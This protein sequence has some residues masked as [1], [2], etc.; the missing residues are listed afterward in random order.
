MV[1]NKKIMSLLH[2]PYYGAR[3][4]KIERRT[5]ESP[6]MSTQII[7]LYIRRFGLFCVCLS[8]VRRSIH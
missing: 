1:E 3:C 2:V 7:R 6:L 5:L 8:E 4:V